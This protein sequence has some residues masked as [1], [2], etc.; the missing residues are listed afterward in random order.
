MCISYQNTGTNHRLAAKWKINYMKGYGYGVQC[1]GTATE[2]VLTSTIGL[3][4]LDKQPISF[5][6][7]K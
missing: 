2:I 4:I 3:L 1:Q 5:N 6:V 7:V